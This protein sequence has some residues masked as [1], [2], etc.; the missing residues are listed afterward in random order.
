MEFASAMAMAPRTVRCSSRWRSTSRLG[1]SQVS[2]GSTHSPGRLRPGSRRGGT[3]PPRTHRLPIVTR[4]ALPGMCSPA[5]ASGVRRCP[6]AIPIHGLDVAR[7]AF[8]RR[9]VS[10]PGEVVE[11]TLR[12]GLGTIALAS[13]RATKTVTVLLT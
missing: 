11:M 4:A 10:G 12:V 2:V 3:A 6:G 7:L 5:R 9:P 1:S 13:P 8:L